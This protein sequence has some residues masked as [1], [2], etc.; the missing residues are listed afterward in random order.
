MSEPILIKEI[1]PDVMKKIQARIRQA[2][3]ERDNYQCR[4]CGAEA[5]IACHTTY[6][7]K[8]YESAEHMISLC[9][10]C[11]DNLSLQTVNSPGVI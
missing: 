7:D 11:H 3:L 9:D 4:N 8:D 5:V 6:D 1:L 10:N 2:V